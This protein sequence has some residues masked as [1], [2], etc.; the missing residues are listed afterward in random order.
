[1]QAIHGNA[2]NISVSK[3]LKKMFVW[4][5]INGKKR[6]NDLIVIFLSKKYSKIIKTNG[7]A[8][9]CTLDKD[10]SVPKSKTSIKGIIFLVFKKSIKLIVLKRKKKVYKMSFR[11]IIHPT[12]SLLMGWME[13]S[14]AIKKA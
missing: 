6:A 13:K 7:R 12:V 11:C 9:A 5:K 10:D 3:G 8:R 4:K 1:M 14:K 2:T